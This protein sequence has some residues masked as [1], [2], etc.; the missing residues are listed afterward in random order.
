VS[1][2][3]EERVT[4]LELRF[5]E[6]ERLLRELSDVMFAQQRE[7]DGLRKQV[8]NLEK[9]LQAEPGLVDATEK[10]RPPHY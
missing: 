3:L 9:K 2:P 5:M 10:E 8:V 7:L 1:S 4:E 6:Q